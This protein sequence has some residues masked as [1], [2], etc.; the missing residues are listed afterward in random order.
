[1]SF[2]I[3]KYADPQKIK[4]VDQQIAVGQ[5]IVDYQ[6]RQDAI[7]AAAMKKQFDD[8][9]LQHTANVNEIGAMRSRFMQE[10]GSMQQEQQQEPPPE[11]EPEPEPA[12]PAP[13]SVP[14]G[15]TLE[16]KQ[17][18]RTGMQDAS[19]AGSN[20]DVQA[21]TQAA[22]NAGVPSTI[23]DRARAQ[24]G[25]QDYNN[26]CEKFVENLQGKSGMFASALDAAKSGDL[27][28]DWKSIQPGDEV[29][30]DGAQ[31]NGGYG[32]VGIY[33]GAG[34]IVSAT[35]HGVKELPINAFNAPVLGFKPNGDASQQTE[36]MAA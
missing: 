14:E 23:L 11:P 17:G 21:A 27:S 12:P 18:P 26:L 28:Q 36:S 2:I 31:E 24:M 8:H 20:G 4:I 30:F 5:K 6:K 35:S 19:V 33:S 9:V 10:F 13:P 22:L 29:Y 3:G 7:E 25:S 1:M 32:H 16:D 15:P 34:N